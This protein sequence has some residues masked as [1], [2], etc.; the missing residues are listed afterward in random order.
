M[1][2]FEAYNETPL[3]ISL[4]RSKLMKPLAV[5]RW[6]TDDEI[7]CEIGCTMLLGLRHSSRQLYV[8]ADVDDLLI[9]AEHQRAGIY[10]GI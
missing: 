4:L 9:V 5:K 8:L 10:H 2:D 6:K 1:K 3:L 7:G